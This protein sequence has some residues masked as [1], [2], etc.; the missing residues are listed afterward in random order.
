MAKEQSDWKSPS[1]D[2]HIH[3]HIFDVH[4][5]PFF[6]TTIYRDVQLLK[7]KKAQVKLIFTP[8]K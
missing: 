2:V 4:V 7:E 1:S 3:Q 6:V 8:L 5:F